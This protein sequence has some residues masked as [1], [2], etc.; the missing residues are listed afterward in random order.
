MGQ[1]LISVGEISQFPERSVTVIV[2]GA[3]ELGIIRWDGNQVYALR[4]VCPHAGGPV[5][6]GRLGP[7]I[8][9]DADNPLGMSVDDECPTL[10]CAWHGWEFDARNGRALAPGSRL[11]VRSYPVRVESGMVLVDLGRATRR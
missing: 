9:A 11:R 4:N 7:R 6:A 8:T 5:C 10:T 2:A 1:Q 3:I